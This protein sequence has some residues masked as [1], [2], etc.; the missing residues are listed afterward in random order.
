MN[1]FINKKCNKIFAPWAETCADCPLKK[2]FKNKEKLPAVEKTKVS[3]NGTI[4]YFNI[5]CY[6]IPHYNKK[7][8]K[9]VISV[10]DITERKNMEKK[11]IQNYKRKMKNLSHKLILAEEHE[12]KRIATTLHAE[13][14]QTLAFL[15]LK[16]SE[17]K[18]K[19]S[20]TNIKE[21]LEEVHNL[22]ENAITSTRSLMTQLSPYILYEL[23]FIP[24]VDW[25]AE[26]ILRE[27]N[28][29]YSF[30]DDG[31]QKPLTNDLS[32]LL[33]QAVRELLAN[34]RKHAKAKN[35]KI[36]IKRNGNNIQIEVSDDGI[37][38]DT[39]ALDS[40]VESDIGFGLLNIRSRID[41]VGGHFEI[42]SYKN[43]GTKIKLAAPLKI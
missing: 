18:G 41:I 23:G 12:R 17:L 37:G 13:V 33:F 7:N 19:E 30:K 8:L 27:N 36:S 1:S 4:R 24:A 11:N 14:G 3:K 38:F 28:I 42:E 6:P 40:Y 39:S 29:K 21:D 2:L 5:Q 34:I 20:P 9:S 10:R 26:H 43:K 31:K 16:I 15:K 25:L 32:I 35:V 22:A